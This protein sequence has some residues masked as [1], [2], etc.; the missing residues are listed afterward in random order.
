MSPIPE[1]STLTDSFDS[2]FTHDDAEL[3]ALMCEL[4]AEYFTEPEEEPDG[5]ESDPCL[6][7][8][9]SDF[10]HND[11]Y[12]G[13]DHSHP[14]LPGYHVVAANLRHGLPWDYGLHDEPEFVEVYYSGNTWKL[15]SGIDTPPKEN[16]VAVL[17][18]FYDSRNLLMCASSI[19]FNNF[20]C[21]GRR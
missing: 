3:A 13:M 1:E 18:V 11:S 6:N 19:V 15:L 20:R 4:P 17:R 7:F 2:L 14:T 12:A 9:Y 8:H 5:S 21:V 16:E 10:Y